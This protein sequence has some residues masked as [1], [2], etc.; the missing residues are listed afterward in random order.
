[1]KSCNATLQ[2]FFKAPPQKTI[3][4]TLVNTG[5][6]DYFDFQGRVQPWNSRS[7]RFS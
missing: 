3:M 7:N 4:D 6:C 5:T 1:M 2:H